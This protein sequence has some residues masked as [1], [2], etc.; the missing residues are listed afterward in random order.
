MSVV[1]QFDFYFFCTVDYL[2]GCA[3][4]T[5]SSTQSFPA[6]KGRQQCFVNTGWRKKRPEHSHAL[7]DRIVKRNQYKNIFVMTEH[8][9]ICVKI[10]AENTSVLAVIQTKECYTP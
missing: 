9:R 6:V 4:L 2:F 8:Q 1:H 3:R 7:F 10:F 5:K